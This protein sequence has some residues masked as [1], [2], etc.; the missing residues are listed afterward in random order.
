MKY[1]I[2]YHLS[3]TDLDGYGAQLMTRNLNPIYLN[4]D[5]Y[6][7]LVNINYIF[8]E[9]YIKRDKKIL[10]LI[11]DLAISEKIAKKINNFFRGNKDID[12]TVQVLDHHK[13]TKDVADQNDWYHFDNTKCGASLTSEYVCREFGFDKKLLEIGKIIQAHDLW[14]KESPYFGVANL[15]S[16]VLFDIYFP[17]F[18]LDEKRKFFLHYIEAFIE[19][20]LTSAHNNVFKLEKLMP[21]ILI[22]CLA[23]TINNEILHDNFVRTLYKVYWYQA[24][25]FLEKKFETLEYKGLK[26]KVLFDIDRGFYQYFSHYVLEMDSSLDFL[27]NIRPSG[28]IS[29]RSV[30]DVDVSLIAQEL[31]NGGGHKHAAAG[32][33]IFDKEIHSY[34]EV[35]SFLKK[36]SYNK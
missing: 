32:K 24:T 34:E 4:T 18:L 16:D 21:D 35:V 7:L 13:T 20:N 26:Y 30:K 11:T 5:Y 17:D 31:C 25:C 27:V 8:S 14:E 36:Y 22:S 2:V 9:I 28:S 3:H 23:K 15:L 19:T 12:L 6:N 29:L 33:V 10:F 1:D